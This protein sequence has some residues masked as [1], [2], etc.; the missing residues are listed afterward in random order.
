MSGIQGIQGQNSFINRFAN[1][2]EREVTACVKGFNR[3]SE[4]KRA[5]TA[6]K[7]MAIVFSSAV[8]GAVVASPVVSVIGIPVAAW[9]LYNATRNYTPVDASLDAGASIAKQV[10][11]NV[12]NLYNGVVDELGI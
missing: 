12:R 4:N 5:E 6:I 10:G 1:F 3:M 11:K 7:T 9:Y 8:L 2:V